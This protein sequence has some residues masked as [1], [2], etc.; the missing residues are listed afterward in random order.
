MGIAALGLACVMLVHRSWWEKAV[1]LASVVPVAVAANVMRIVVT[2]VAWQWVT[3]EDASRRAH[4]WAGYAMVP[5]AAALFAIVLWYLG[6]LVESVEVVDMG[7]M[8]RRQ[9]A[10]M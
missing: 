6:K 3:T 9:R 7:D 8:V 2:A 5:F 1:L 10:R 4:D